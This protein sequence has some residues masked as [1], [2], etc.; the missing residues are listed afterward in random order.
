LQ[1]AKDL[2]LLPFEKH[3]DLL[4]ETT[5]PDARKGDSAEVEAPTQNMLLFA[6]KFRICLGSVNWLNSVKDVRLSFDIDREK[7]V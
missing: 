1:I 4:K 5:P 3:K 6:D 7:G 2:Q